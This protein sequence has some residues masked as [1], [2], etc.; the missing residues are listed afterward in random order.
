MPVA[1]YRPSGLK[2]IVKTSAG[3]SAMVI[4][5][6][7]FLRDET[8]V[9]TLRPSSVASAPASPAAPAL[10][11]WG[12]GAWVQSAVW[13][14]PLRHRGGRGGWRAP[15]Y[16]GGAGKPA[17]MISV[18]YAGTGT[19]TASAGGVYRQHLVVGSSVLRRD[20][21]L[22]GRPHRFFPSTFDGFSRSPRSS[23]SGIMYSAA[24]SAAPPAKNT[25]Q[26]NTGNIPIDRRRT[27]TADTMAAEG[28][29][30]RPTIRHHHQLRRCRSTAALLTHPPTVN[31][32]QPVAS[33]SVRAP[34]SCG[35]LSASQDTVVFD[36]QMSCGG[37]SG[38]CTRILKKMDGVEEVA[39][40][41]DAQK[42]TVTG[43]EL[44]P[45]E[46]MLAALK[47]WG[48][49]AGKTVELAQ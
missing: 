44:P 2:P 8:V 25:C 20:A 10:C 16:P 11:R 32:H 49:A 45:A 24:P 7:S 26:A 29:R 31:P 5:G 12:G 34:S 39:C 41:L 1:R 14:V 6:C 4:E 40:D 48:E 21:S 18:V 17:C 23:R 15:Y 47:K 33:I 3:L 37:C 27:T 13:L 28:V 30:A 46:D 35:W 22:A 9:G 38:A 43:A 42:V 19:G 36:V